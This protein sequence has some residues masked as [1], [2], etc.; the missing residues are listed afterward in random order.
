[1]GLTQRGEI[2]QRR[3]QNIHPAAAGQAQ[4]HHPRALADANAL[5]PA[6]CDHPPRLADDRRLDTTAG[7]R[8][9]GRA[10]RP[11]RHLRANRPRA[12][13]EGRG[14]AEQG[15]AARLCLQQK[16]E[17]GQ[18]LGHGSLLMGKH[19]GCSAAGAPR[20]RG[21]AHMVRLTAWH[22]GQPHVAE[23]SCLNLDDLLIR[24]RPGGGAV[25]KPRHMAWLAKTKFRASS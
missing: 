15:N 1:M 13:A 6:A 19:R 22:Q 21:E 3:D 23:K 20:Q 14:D 16:P 18:S 17:Q 2:R 9:E 24:G 12:A 5:W 8:A 7:E 10:I 4:I 11:H 25:A